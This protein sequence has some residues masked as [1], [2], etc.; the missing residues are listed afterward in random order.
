MRRV[1]AVVLPRLAC[2]L[3]RRQTGE[4]RPPLAVVLGDG[5]PKDG[6]PPVE[7]TSVLDA[8]SGEARRYGVRVGQTAAEARALVADLAVELVTFSTLREALGAV[9]E[10]ALA[11]A[12]RVGFELGDAT[13][14]LDTVYL[15]VGG[16]AHLAGGEAALASELASRVQKLGHLVRVAVADGGRIARAVALSATRRETVVPSGQGEAAMA[17]LPVAALPL[18]RDTAAWLAKVGVATVGDLARLPAS[19]ASARLGDR[20]RDAIELA[21]GRDAA[22]I[23]P[24]EP[25]RAPTE[26]VAWE[27]GVSSIEPLAFALRGLVARLSARLDGRGEATGS[28][29][30]RARYDASI[31]KL[32]GVAVP[33]LVARIEL[34]APLSH[35]ADLFRATKAKLDTLVLEAPVKTLSVAA[36]QVTRAP[37]V[38]LDLGRDAAVSPDALPV[39]LAELSAELGPSRLG[40]LSPIAAHR[41]EARAKLV[42]ADARS[43]GRQI[44]LALPLP[45]DDRLPTRLLPCSVALPMGLPAPGNALPID[46]SFFTVESSRGHFRLD[47]IEWWTREP[48]ARDYARVWLSA[49]RTHVEAWIYRD[50]TTGEAF[51]QGFYD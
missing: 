24:Y 6:R 2:E 18:E 7:P 45:T 12:P 19:A 25:P 4:I 11:Y 32:R 44:A 40:V 20:A 34:P 14:P 50:R 47:Q 49:P 39:L 8:V 28:L 23:T 37:R 29:E 3:A 35:E 42:P 41:P 17:E 36:V 22:P 31:A 27:D 16:S 46:G 13:G 15:D 33:E 43:A 26:Q 9:A 5:A 21:S 10:V 1:I 48:V 38:Q 30:L 51:L